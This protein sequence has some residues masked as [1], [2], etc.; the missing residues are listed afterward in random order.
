MDKPARARWT[1][2]ESDRHVYLE[3]ARR[4]SELTLPFLYPPSGSSGATELPTPYNSLGARAVNNLSSKLLLTLLP[5]NT[6]FFR[7]T[8]SREVVRQAEA[9]EM[10]VQLDQAFS[11]MERAIVEE[12]EADPVRPVLFDA[13]RHLIVGGNGLLRLDPKHG[14]R[15]YS[16]DQYVVERVADTVTELVVKEK[17]ATESLDKDILDA[18]PEEERA[19]IGDS[20]DVYTVC[21]L[22]DGKYECHQ[23][24]GGII[25]PG[26]VA[27]YIEEEFPYIVLRWNRISNEN[28]GRGIV[29]E[30]L[31]DLNSL[32][33]IT[34]SIVEFSLAASRLL[35][36]VR[37]N[38]A[39]RLTDVQ[40]APNGAIKI[41]NAEDV[42][43]LQMQKFADFNVSMNVGTA[44]QQ[45]L[46]HAFLLRS[47]VQRN[48]E[49]V[50][51]TEVRIMAQELEDA[52][53]GVFSSLAGDLQLPLIRVTLA[54]M[55]KKKKLRKLPEGIVRPVVITGIDAL[56]RGHELM[57]LDTFVSGIGQTLGP[58]A[59]AQYLD[60]TGYMAARAAAL[61]LDVAG[62][63]KSPEQIAQ[64]QAAA[65]Q[66]AA[67]QQM[68][69][70]LIK[71]GTQLGVAQM[72]QQGAQ[73]VAT[74]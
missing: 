60:V 6:P 21:R 5:P 45:R 43:V 62:I 32:E 30:Y 25:V 74:E 1:K 53:G 42:T 34:R 2:L 28:Y 38:G 16:L 13:L 71:A 52:L 22:A 41:G 49:R 59:L 40:N 66:Q 19:R 18:L 17:V 44:I 55:Q 11:E 67:Q 50:T 65:Q 33:A 58:Q 12:L 29:E 35:F 57:K 54:M 69:P 70:E 8:V 73:G 48:A 24:V 3:R 9:T 31:G 26:T 72:K 4:C 23:E 10:L 14:W 27:S 51:A 46:E 56:G 20:V 61:G 64:E 15:F 68:A 39:T 7:F 36:F 37:P 63:V 47:S